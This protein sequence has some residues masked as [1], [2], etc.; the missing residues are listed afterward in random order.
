[1]KRRLAAVAAILLAL[2]IGGVV[3]VRQP[4]ATGPADPDRGPAPGAPAGS[5]P[6][7]AP[8]APGT[9]A[10][11]A[12]AAELTA[13][14]MRLLPGAR[15]MVEGFNDPSQPPERDLAIIEEALAQFRRVFGRN[16]P[17][18]ENAEIVA[19]LLG[20]NAKQLAVIPPDLPAVNA[21]GELIDRW[22]TPFHFHP[23]SGSVM[24]VLSAGPDRALWTPDDLGT[25]NPVDGPEVP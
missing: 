22:N 1:M 19:G 6:S 16:P 15:E 20:G 17:G 21:A 14:G 23:V 3:M 9:G 7:A 10:P 4:A 25:L 18:G 24:E 8:G 13:D 11:A 5:Q 2:G 12:D